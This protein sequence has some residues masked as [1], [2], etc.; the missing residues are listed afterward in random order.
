M[1]T[2][3]ILP[4][5]NGTVAC[6]PTKREEIEKCRFCVHSVRF[7]IP[8][9][10]IPSPARAFCTMSR[11]TEEVDLKAVISVFCDDSRHEGF[12]SIMNVIG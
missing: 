9:R 12:R 2:T 4:V 10:E 1:S 3:R 6:L 7:K 8:G 5:E 11:A